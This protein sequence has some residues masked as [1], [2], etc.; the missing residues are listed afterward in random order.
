MNSII[1]TETPTLHNSANNTKEEATAPQQTTATK[2]QVL[3][4]EFEATEDGWISFAEIIVELEDEAE[5]QTLPPFRFNPAPPSKK[6]APLAGLKPIT[7]KTLLPQDMLK[8]EQALATL[9]EEQQRK[10][11][12]KWTLNQPAFYLKYQYAIEEEPKK[13]KKVNCIRRFLR[14]LR[15]N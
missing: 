9:Q 14:T 15:K 1:N 10:Q 2:H 5:A 3:I 11:E 13:E 6:L 8:E 4:E 7:S 12:Q